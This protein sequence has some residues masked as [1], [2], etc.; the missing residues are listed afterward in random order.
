MKKLMVAV[1]MVISTIVSVKAQF[2]NQAY[3]YNDDRYYYD[4][5]FD[6]HW[7]I[8]VK[9]SDG[10]QRGLLTQNES[11]RLY[12]ILEDV[13]R[14][15]YVYQEDGLFSGWEQ[16]E[17]WDNVIYLNQ[18]LG[19]ELTDYD[20]NFYG[21][22][23]YGYNR[24][25]NSKWFYQ[26]GYDFFR[27][28]KRG[29]GNTRLGYAPRSN[30]NGWCRNNNNYIARR[31]YSER[32]RYDA[33]SSNYRGYDRGNWDNRI[34]ENHRDRDSK[35]DNDY[36]RN[37]FYGNNNGRNNSQGNNENRRNDR[38]EIPDNRSN[39]NGDR[40]PNGGGRPQRIEP[41][42]NES[43]FPNTY[44]RPERADIPRSNTRPQSIESPQIIT[45]PER[46]ESP[47]GNGGTKF[48][49]ADSNNRSDVGSRNDANGRSEAPQSGT[50][51][52][53]NRGPR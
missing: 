45:R 35:R 49:R 31:Y 1:L 25:G 26:G 23:L 33:R 42:N 52:G 29:F 24:R 9:I 53:G 15:E 6:W 28:D 22:D 36:N 27:F 8:R 12:G 50:N 21:F 5:D 48:E 18:R 14:R 4:N 13:E 30:Y 2:G 16:Q 41:N 3:A 32:P 40:F 19:V 39:N 34:N 44:T 46:V 37:R 47:Q 43:G 17:I 20:R 10:I 11:N 38:V 7:D 51:G